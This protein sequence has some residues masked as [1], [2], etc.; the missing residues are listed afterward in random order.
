MKREKIIGK[1]IGVLY[2]DKRKDTIC[3]LPEK[4]R[5]VYIVPKGFKMTSNR[6]TT[7]DETKLLERLNQEE[8]TV[9]Y[10][11]NTLA[12]SDYVL[13]GGTFIIK[14]IQWA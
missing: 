1:G 9:Y 3:F 6:G 4:S 7:I 2:Y 10:Y 13:I 12:N 8:I 14:D 11:A 5:Q